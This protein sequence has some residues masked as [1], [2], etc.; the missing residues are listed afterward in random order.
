[1][2]MV[3]FQPGRL[4]ISGDLLGIHIYSTQTFHLCPT[5]L[6]IWASA[7]FSLYSISWW[8]HVGFHTSAMQ[9]TLNSL[10]PSFPQM[11]LFLP[12]SQHLLMD[13]SWNFIPEKLNCCSSG[14]CVLLEQL[15]DLSFSHCKQPSNSCPSPLMLISYLQHQKYFVVC[16]Y[17]HRPVP[18]GSCSV[19]CHFETT[20]LADLP[21]GTIPHLELI[22]NDAAVWLVSKFSK[23]FWL[24]TKSRAAPTNVKPLIA[25]HLAPSARIIIISTDSTISQDLQTLLCSSTLV[26]EW[27]SSRV[28]QCKQCLKPYLFLKPA[29]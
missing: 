9:M 8:S 17:P 16:L 25:P 14:S 29:L 13:G 15:S 5:R 10:F 28:K 26:M 21:L 2:A 12:R 7:V 4:V 18:Y 27:T 19:P 24:S 1:M 23:F 22:Q 6:D 11:L 20:I 3:C